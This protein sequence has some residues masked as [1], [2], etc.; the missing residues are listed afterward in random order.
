MSSLVDEAKRLFPTAILHVCGLHGRVGY[1]SRSKLSIAS[2]V[3]FELSRIRKQRGFT[4]ENLKN[5][6]RKIRPAAAPGGLKQK[7][8]ANEQAACHTH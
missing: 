3:F 4:A 2:I 1:L 6:G 8:T 5:T 7:L